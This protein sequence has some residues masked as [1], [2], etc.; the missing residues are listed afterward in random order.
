MFQYLCTVKEAHI[1][2]HLISL[3]TWKYTVTCTI[4]SNGG[5]V[6]NTLFTGSGGV[7]L[8]QLQPTGQPDALGY[9]NYSAMVTRVSGIHGDTYHCKAYNS[10]SAVSDTFTLS[11]ILLLLTATPLQW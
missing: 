4:T 11:G 3:L 5:P 1:S 10:V 2:F 6:L 8:G 9:Y 7:D